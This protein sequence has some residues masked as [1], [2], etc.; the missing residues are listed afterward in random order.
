MEPGVSHGGAMAASMVA[1][2]FVATAV[3]RTG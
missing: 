3:T 1:G 2:A